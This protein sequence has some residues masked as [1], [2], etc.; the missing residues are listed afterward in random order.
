MSVCNSP[1][2]LLTF[3]QDAGSNITGCDKDFLREILRDL[4]RVSHLVLISRSVN[5]CFPLDSTRLWLQQID[6]EI[7]RLIT[8][9]LIT[10]DKTRDT[11]LALVEKR[12]DKIESLV[13]LC[14]SLES[15]Y[16]EYEQKS[17]EKS[18]RLPPGMARRSDGLLW[19]AWGRN[20]APRPNAEQLNRANGK[21]INLPI[22]LQYLPRGCLT[23]LEH[24]RKDVNDVVDSILQVSCSRGACWCN[25]PDQL[26]NTFS[27]QRP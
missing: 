20:L 11:F 17:V 5:D 3:D 14:D 1:R 18:L 27:D 21:G 16:H 4:E 24:W 25:S 23:I 12:V 9:K 22:R 15:A 2:I 10:R 7:E 8:H 13:E 26:F 19:P 6:S